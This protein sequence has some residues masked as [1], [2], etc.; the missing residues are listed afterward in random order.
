MSTKKLASAALAG[1]LTA[2][3]MATSVAQAHEGNPSPKEQRNAAAERAAGKHACNGKHS[4]KGG[5]NCKTDKNSCKGQSA[6][7]GHHNCG[8]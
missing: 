8:K 4:C 1:L 5:N 6:C 7:K 2:G 3:I